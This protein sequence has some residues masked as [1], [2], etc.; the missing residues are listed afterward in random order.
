MFVA[1]IN[2][3]NHQIFAELNSVKSPRRKG[4]SSRSNDLAEG[5]RHKHLLILKVNSTRVP[6]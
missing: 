1:L 2:Y 4:V 6:G 3:S 5:P